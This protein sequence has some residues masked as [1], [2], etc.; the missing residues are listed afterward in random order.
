[1]R[2]CPPDGVSGCTEALQRIRLDTRAVSLIVLRR[3][4]D[5]STSALAAAFCGSTS[6]RRLRFGN[7]VLY[8]TLH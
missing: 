5:H 1:M 7:R 8:I 6:S 3:H 4:A 2:P